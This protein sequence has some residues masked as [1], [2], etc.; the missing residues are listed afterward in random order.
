METRGRPSKFNIAFSE[1]ILELYENG[2][3]DEQV[4]DIIGVHVRTIHNWKKSQPDFLHALREGKQAADDL[5]EASFFSSA[6]GYSHPEEKIFQ[7]EGQI[8]RA[9]TTKH[10]PP[11]ARAAH[12]WLQNRR[13]KDWKDT[14]TVV[15]EGGEKPIQI[16]ATDL[17]D[18][19]KQIKG[20]E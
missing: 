17:E 3:T 11:D 13:P 8:I 15:H 6:V 9:E 2:K 7:Y 10:Y 18:R 14:K 12:I 4:A 20:E 1:K 16:Q 5:V 19:L